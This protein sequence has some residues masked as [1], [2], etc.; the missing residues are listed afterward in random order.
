MRSLTCLVVCGAVMVSR[1]DAQRPFRLG[2]TYHRIAVDDGSGANHTYA[3]YGGM[4]AYLS[5]DDGEIAF[6]AS[7]YDDLSNDACV[8]Q[9]TFYGVDS[10]FYP[11][12]ATGVAPFATAQVGLARVTEADAPLL[13]ACSVSTPVTTT[14][15]LG[16]GYGIGVRVGGGNVAGLIEGRFFQV[17][18]SFI[19][20]LEVRANAS[21]AFGAPRETELL[22]GTLGPVVSWWVPLGGT[23]QAR[24]PLVGVRFRRD[25]RKAGTIGL[26]LDYAPLEIT[27]G[28]TQFCEPLAILFQP[29][30]EASVHP[31]WGRAF[32]QLGF[33]LAGFPNDGPDRGLA[34]GLHG[35]L[36]VDIYS[37]AAMWNLQSRALWLQRNTGENVFAVLVGVSV[38]PKLVHPKVAAAP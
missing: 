15:E 7:R 11:V 29:A 20:G 31:R 22:R 4:F 36:G 30:Y 14:S 33:V 26:Q 5:R 13:F 17:P 27:G 28:C 8:R 10:Y 6:T 16:V 12:G 34:Q 25:T 9:M 24:G 32:G 23:L 3:A 21:V 2:P 19:Q 38:S 1:A 37:G 35:G 18:N